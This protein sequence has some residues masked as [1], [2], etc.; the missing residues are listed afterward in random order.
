MQEMLGEVLA[1]PAPADSLKAYE[2]AVQLHRQ[3]AAAAAERANGAANG[4]QVDHADSDAAAAAA[5]AGPSARLLNNAAVMF[6]RASQVED[7]RDLIQEG[8]DRINDGAR[9]SML[10]VRACC[11]PA[12]RASFCILQSPLSAERVMP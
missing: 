2:R 10:S 8:I 3:A 7:A 4:M 11:N 9:L 1:I 5:R 12:P 6:Y